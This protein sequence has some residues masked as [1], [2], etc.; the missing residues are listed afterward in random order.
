LFNET[1]NNKSNKHPRGTRKER[2]VVAL[3]VY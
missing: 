1:T 3:T 2:H